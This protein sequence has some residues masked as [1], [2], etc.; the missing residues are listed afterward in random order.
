MEGY[1]DIHNHI[2][3]K[4][5]DGARSMNQALQMLEIAFSEGIRTII[6]TPHISY[7]RGEEKHSKLKAAYEALKIQA[8]QQ[9][10][11]LTLCFGGEIFYSQ[12]TVYGLQKNEIP[13]LGNTS[14]VLVEFQPAC[15][16]RYLKTSIQ[17]LIIGGYK[18]VIAHVERYY[19]LRKDRK[20]LEELLLMGAYAQSNASSIR[21]EDGREIQRFVKKLL[22]RR[23]LH[24]VATDSHGDEIRPPRIRECINMA[25][26]KYGEE[27]ATDLFI[28]NGRKLLKDQYI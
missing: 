13:T 26:K 19:V 18:P 27:Y 5:D 21:G 6:A 28:H 25:K 16:Y 23:L 20:L 24:F 17:N 1:I 3:P 9:F 4:V 14:Y 11:E 22:K 12:D 2:I 15:E 7:R 10:P 8:E